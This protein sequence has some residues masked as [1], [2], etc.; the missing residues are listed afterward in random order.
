MSGSMTR[1]QAAPAEAMDAPRAGRCAA[2]ASLSVRD[3]SVSRGYRQLFRAFGFELERGTVV[4]I[5]G[6]NG[7]GKTTL[8][9]I[10]CGLAPLQH[11]EI[12]WHYD[13]G[14]LRTQP[15]PEDI[16]Y[17]AHRDGLSESLS[18]FENLRFAMKLRGNYSRAAAL[19]ALQLVGLEHFAHVRAGRLSAG[20][21]RRAAIARLAALDAPLWILDEPLT[22][23]DMD[24]IGMFQRVLSAHLS[25]GGMAVLTTHQSIE[26]EQHTIVTRELG[27][28]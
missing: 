13:D 1:A 20:Q 4:Q 7:S 10:L 15:R 2:L 28:P 9:R 19:S 22:S 12:E 16:C 5:A 11:G 23:I 25:A 18:P 27:Q 3:L 8:V 26:L 6:G 21:R 24:G 14:K 17:L